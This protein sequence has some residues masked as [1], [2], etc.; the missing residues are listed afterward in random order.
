L[1]NQRQT[2]LASSI[3]TATANTKRPRNIHTIS[4]F[5]N[6]VHALSRWTRRASGKIHD[7]SLSHSPRLYVALPAMKS[8][9]K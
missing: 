3:Q 5:S 9:L 4:R 2:T 7:H 8:L 1:G 6:I